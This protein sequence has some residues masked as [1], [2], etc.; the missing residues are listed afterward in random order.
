[1]KLKYLLFLS[2]LTITNL[3]SAAAADEKITVSR[4]KWDA[5]RVIHGLHE[6]ERNQYEAILSHLGSHI[7][8]LVCAPYINADDLA[9]I[10]LEA[11]RFQEALYEER[12]DALDYDLATRVARRNK[13]MLEHGLLSEVE[14]E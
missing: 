9:R 13:F 12:I 8:K 6:Q 5:A 3:Y 2:C 4:K 11:K 7:S 10:V 1:M 14:K